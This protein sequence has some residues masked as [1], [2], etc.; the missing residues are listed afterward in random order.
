MGDTRFAIFLLVSS[1][2]GVLLFLMFIL[3]L[4]D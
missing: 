2:A 1:A 3:S 4:P